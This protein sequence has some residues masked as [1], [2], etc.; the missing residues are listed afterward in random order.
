MPRPRSRSRRA[1][2]HRPDI[3]DDNAGSAA[4]TRASTRFASRAWYGQAPRVGRTSRAEHEVGLAA[5]TGAATDGRS[6]PS[7]DASQSMKHTTS[8]VAAARPA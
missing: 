6:C 7:N 1:A 3:G 5:R 2:A 8:A 4:T